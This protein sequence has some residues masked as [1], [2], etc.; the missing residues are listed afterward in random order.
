MRWLAEKFPRGIAHMEPIMV[1]QIKEKFGGLC[2]YYNGGD[3]E[4][5]GMSSLAESLSYRICEICGST[6]DIGMTQGWLRTVCKV[7][8]ETDEWCK[9]RTWV[10]S[11]DNVI[12]SGGLTVIRTD[13]DLK[14]D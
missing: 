4:I 2:F 13:K 8:S 11:N 10:M 1:T 7:C 12:K 3:N 14:D 9:D 6:K 5:W